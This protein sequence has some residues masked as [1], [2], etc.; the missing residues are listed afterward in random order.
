MAAIKMFTWKANST[1]IR[2]TICNIIVGM[3]RYAPTDSL[4]SCIHIRLVFNK[5]TQTKT[6]EYNRNSLQRQTKQ[7]EKG[8]L[9]LTK[10]NYVQQYYVY[11]ELYSDLAVSVY[12]KTIVLKSFGLPRIGHIPRTILVQ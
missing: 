10:Q 8:R 4:A 1:D 5:Q 3:T 11:T 2:Y 12:E 7:Y 6:M 9:D